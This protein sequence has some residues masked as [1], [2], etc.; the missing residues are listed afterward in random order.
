MA[1][2]SKSMKRESKAEVAADASSHAPIPDVAN[3]AAR[4]AKAC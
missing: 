4:I 3:H 1:P 2:K